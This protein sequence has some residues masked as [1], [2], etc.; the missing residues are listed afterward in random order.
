MAEGD[1]E[2][3]D[4]LDELV[5]LIRQVHSDVIEASGGVLGER[6][7]YLYSACAK[8]FQSAFEEDIYV[9]AYEQAAALFHGIICDH[10]FADGNKRTGTLAALLLLAA[11][12]VLEDNE[13]SNLQVRLLGEVALEAAQ[14]NLTVKQVTDWVR[15]ILMP[16]FLDQ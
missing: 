10:P 13:P 3:V 11:L 2:Q 5:E 14:G 8:P 15:R 7:S 4:W 9:T 12:G 1:G 16:S 6:T